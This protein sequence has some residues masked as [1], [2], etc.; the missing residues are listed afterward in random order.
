LSVD[1]LAR[2]EVSGVPASEIMTRAW[3]GVGL[4]S[5][6]AVE[7]TLRAVPYFLCGWLDFNGL[8]YMQQF[9]RFGAGVMLETP[10][11]ILFIPQR[12]TI[13][14]KMEFGHDSAKVRR[15]WQP[16]D[17]ARLD[18]IMFRSTPALSPTKCA[19]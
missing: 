12:L 6:V 3:C 11:E 13:S 14:P 16:V 17:H 9:A 19:S 18:Q 8:G 1:Q 10:D 2:I 7:C 4:D 15:L 5:S